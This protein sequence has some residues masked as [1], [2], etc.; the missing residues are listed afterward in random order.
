VVSSSTYRVVD[1]T[2]AFWSFWGAHGADD[3]TS[4]AIAFKATVIGAHPELFETTVVGVDPTRKASDLDERLGP[5]LADL[6]NRID[7]MRRVSGQVASDLQRYDSSF[8]TLFPDMGWHG[9]LYFTLSIDA[10]DGAIRRVAGEACLLFGIDKIAKLH[11]R[12]ANLGP[13]FHHELF[14]VHHNDVNPPPQMLDTGPH[15]LLEPLW[16]EGLAVYVSSILHEGATP[17]ELLLSEDMI[18][19]G[20]QELPQLAAELRRLLD[21]AQEVDYRDF[22][23]GRGQRAGVPKRVAYFIGFLV[24]KELAK[25]RSIPALVQ[26][27]GSELRTAVDG[28]LAGFVAQ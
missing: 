7:T 13:L 9:T 27:R 11:G 19:E 14:H 17:N 1:A 23:L 2:A 28:V 4:Q 22:F 24:A 8:R 3:P 10:F 12:S 26:L 21:D 5:F 20:T 18:R 6:P 16:R 25:S 15:G